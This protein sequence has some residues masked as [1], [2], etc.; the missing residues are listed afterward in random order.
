MDYVEISHYKGFSVQALVYRHDSG[1]AGTHTRLY[2]VSVR[3]RREDDSAQ[4]ASI[5]KLALDRP[6]LNLGDARR[7]GE[8]HARKIINGAVP[9]SSVEELGSHPKA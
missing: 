8:A 1:E 5:F 6:F 9:G 2:D 4:A 7:A 3:I